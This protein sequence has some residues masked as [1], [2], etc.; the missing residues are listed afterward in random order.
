MITVSQAR[1]TFDGMEVF[2]NLSFEVS[3]RSICAIV[4]PTGCGKSTLLNLI[5]KL[6]N[7]DFG[8]VVVAC[9]GAKIGYMMQDPLLLPWRTLEENA[10]LGAEIVLGRKLE[11]MRSKPYL[12]EFDLWKDR[13]KYPD[14]A[15]GGMKQRLALLRTLLLKPTTDVP[16]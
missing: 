4:G 8:T 6:D 16:G 5:A 10:T 13:H 7:L 3:E 1:K 15:S 2:E 12:E 14:A 9:S 11:P